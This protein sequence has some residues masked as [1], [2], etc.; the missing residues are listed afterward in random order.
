MT[1]HMSEHHQTKTNTKTKSRR[2]G[3]KVIALTIGCLS[4]LGVGSGMI[5]AAPQLNTYTPQQPITIQAI[6]ASSEGDSAVN[7]SK[8]VNKTMAAITG[9]T[10]TIKLQENASTGYSWS[11]KADPQLKFIKEVEVSPIPASVDQSNAP[12]VGVPNDKIW[13]FKA[14]ESGTYKVTFQY[15]RPWEKDTNPVETVVYTIKV[16]DKKAADQ[17]NVINKKIEAVAGQTFNIKLE[18]NDSTGYAWSYKAD[19]QLKFVKEAEQ[20]TASKSKDSDPIVGAPTN[21]T[22]T[23]QASKPGTYKLTFKYERAWE[24]GAKPAKTVVYTVHVK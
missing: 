10:F 13:T 4:L 3:L 6:D 16:S 24:Q 21:K 23:F 7:E 18:Q 9:H 19:E 14:T 12:I 22:W 11:Y 2:S 17:S 8:V 1:N 15:T 5:Y 20:D